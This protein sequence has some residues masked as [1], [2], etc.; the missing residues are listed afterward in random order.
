MDRLLVSFLNT[1]FESPDPLESALSAAKWWASVHSLTSGLTVTVRG[2]PR[3]DRALLESLRLLRQALVAQSPS[4]AF[5]GSEAAD[6]VLFPLA[7]AAT[8]LLNSERA[9]RLK[10]CRRQ[11]CS[12]YFLDETKNGSRR[13]CSLRCMERARA[14][15]R[16]TISR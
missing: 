16:R 1:A 9:R 4:L 7:Y 5:S 13:W 8:A 3:F 10:T 11:P 2:K 12:R 14:P 6:T 15:R